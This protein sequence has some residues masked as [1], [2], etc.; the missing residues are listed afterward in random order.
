MPVGIDY[1]C[2][3]PGCPTASCNDA[4]ILADPTR[5]RV[6]LDASIAHQSPTGLSIAVVQMGQHVFCSMAHAL[7]W[8]QSVSI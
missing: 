1:K 5:Q 6:L 3:L 4:D 8:A 7:V 2:D